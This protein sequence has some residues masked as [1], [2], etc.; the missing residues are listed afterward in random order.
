MEGRLDIPLNGPSLNIVRQCGPA[1]CDVLQSKFGCVATIDGVDFEGQQKKPTVAPEKR[2]E[3]QLHSDVRVSVWKGDL[4]NFQVDAVVNAAN[5]YLQHHGGLA[6]ALATAGG[7]QIQKESDAYTRKHGVLKTGNAI[8]CDSGSLPCKKIIHAVGPRLSAYPNKY[9]VSQAEP[10][11]Q[12]AIISILNKVKESHLNTVAIPAISS[13]LFN[14]P[15]QECAN[16]I[17]KT[18]KAYYEKSSGHRPKEIQF[19]N[20]DEPTVWEMERACHQILAHNKPKTYSQAA[21]STHRSDAKSSTLTVQ[22]GNVHLTLKKGNIEDQKTDVIVNTTQ[23]RYLSGVISTALQKKAG[24]EMQQEM[25][26]AQQSGCIII[27]QPYNLQCKAV[28][29][30]LFTGMEYGHNTALMVDFMMC[31]RAETHSFPHRDDIPGS[32]APSPQISLSGPSNEATRE[33]ERWLHDL[34]KTNG[35]VTICNNFIQHFGEK[36]HLQLSRL[37]KKGISIAEIFDKSRASMV[38]KGNSAEDV[39]VAGLQ[40]EAMLCNIQREFVREEERTMVVMSSQN[41]SFER[42]MVDQSTSEFKDILSA[43]KYTDLSIVKVDKVENAALKLLF[44]LKKRQLQCS[45]KQMFQRIP[46]Q[47][48][49]MVS[50]IGFHAEYAPPDDPAYGEGIYF[51]NTVKRAMEVWKEPY[52]EYVHFVEAEVL[53]GNSTGGKRGLILPPAMG[54][55]PFTLYNSLSGPE[56]S[57]VFSGYQALPKY[58]ITCKIR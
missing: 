36:E 41:V 56:I 52:S 6:S 38:V 46:A 12:K 19:V 48:C 23:D 5:E 29:H 14:Y 37:M 33:A 40:V 17:V 8:V 43:F 27:T 21:G 51:A 7:P 20:N 10:L 47:F 55:D 25:Y 34:F 15:L 53:T 30:V 42:K 22:M 2:F 50:H 18:V 16:T 13:G 57:V 24:F 26:T 31:S 9:E 49:E 45:T 44:N 32:R 4:T 3:V 28:Y 54:T 58:I 39:V 11:L 1:L 35:T